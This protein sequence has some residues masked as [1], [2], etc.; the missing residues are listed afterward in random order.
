MNSRLRHLLITGGVLVLASTARASDDWHYWNLL[1]L[2]HEFNDTVALDIASEQKWRDDVS[3]LFL[4]SVFIVPTLRLTENVSVGAGYRLERKEDGDSWTSEN[5]LLFPLTIGWT[6]KPWLLQLRN[7]LEYRDLEDEQD[8][9]RI[10][11]RI[12]LKRPVQIGRLAVTPFASEEVFYDF[13]VE[14]MNQNRAA[15]GLSVPWRRHAT[16]TVYYMN[17]AERDD[18]WSIANVLG[19]EVT[20][21]F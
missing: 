18:D 5:R 16:L 14:Q 13:T 17:K 7:Q 4:Y 2:K 12:V 19:T 20:F 11:E 21:K 3:D 8:R 9:W 10:R 15:V 6:V 1:A